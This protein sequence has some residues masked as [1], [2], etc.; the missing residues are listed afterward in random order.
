MAL[1]I[2]PED[3][4]RKP[5]Q[6]RS[7]PIPIK[8]VPGLDDALIVDALEHY[9]VSPTPPTL[10]RKPNGMLWNTATV[11]PYAELGGQAV[12]SCEGPLEVDGATPDLERCD[13]WR[14]VSQSDDPSRI[15]DR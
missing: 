7:N 14:R 12:P 2:S 10:E 9:E 13:A 15:R 6:K 11:T 5:V 8:V 1:R 3:T 4:A